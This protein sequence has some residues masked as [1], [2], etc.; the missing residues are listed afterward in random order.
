L[1]ALIVT[2]LLIMNFAIGFQ[3]GIETEKY[4]TEARYYQIQAE[5]YRVETSINQMQ[6]A[7][8]SHQRYADYL[9]N[10]GI[11]S[12]YTSYQQEMDWVQVYTDNI[13]LLSELLTLIKKGSRI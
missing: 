2:L 10:G 13:K 4:Y 12:F 8:N 5:S 6:T 11:P 3:M 1:R 7:R 9:A